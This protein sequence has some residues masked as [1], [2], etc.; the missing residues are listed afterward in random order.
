MAKWLILV[1]ALAVLI[2]VL[3]WQLRSGSYKPPK[4]EATAPDAAQRALLPRFDARPRMPES[5]DAAQPLP[6]YDSGLLVPGTAAFNYKVDITIND[7]FR[8]RV[9]SCYEGG[10]DGNLSMMLGY[11]LRIVDG[12]VVATDVRVLRSE[13]NNA[14]L[15]QCFVDRLRE[16][17]WSERDMPNFEEQESELFI[18]LRALRK[19]RPIEEQEKGTYRDNVPGDPADPGALGDD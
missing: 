15:E 7:G 3:A 18:R 13:L 8:A 4:I 1:A 17:R 5:H 12:D 9:A 11:T 10:L 6:V 19:Y 14:S 2:A 16:A